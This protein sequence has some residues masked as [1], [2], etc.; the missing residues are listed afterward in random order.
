MNYK[1]DSELFVCNA[2][3]P[4]YWPDHYETLHTVV[5]RIEKSISP[6]IPK[7]GCIADCGRKQIIKNITLLVTQSGNKAQNV[8]ISDSILLLI[9]NRPY[10]LC[11]LL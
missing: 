8:S 3:R 5:H 1:C 9:N 2:S 10:N 11:P 4:N 7:T 6:F